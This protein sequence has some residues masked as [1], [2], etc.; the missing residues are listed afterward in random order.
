MKNYRKCL[1]PL[2]NLPFFLTAARNKS[3]STA[4]KELF[5][6][7]AAV[8]KRIQRLE[9]WLG[10]DLF[11]RNGRNLKIS[12]AGKEFASDVEMALDFL[13][14][15]VRKIKSPEEPVVRIATGTTISAYW[16]YERL[17]TFS[18]SE[19][20]CNIYVSTSDSTAEVMSESNDLFVLFCD[21]Y[22]QGLKCMK[23]FDCE[24]APAAAPDVAD[25]IVHSGIF[26]DNKSNSDTPPLLEY[27]NMNPDWVNWEIWLREMGKPEIKHWP[28]LQCDSFIESIAKARAGLGICLMH[29]PMM[30]KEI[31]DGALVKIDTQSYIT[32]KSYYLCHHE[33]T[34][35][36]QNA[37]NLLEF[38]LGLDM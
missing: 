9:S 37:K 12:N 22:V 17:Q 8:S 4:A 24:L 21:G 1:P 26:S 15:A 36:S 18:R 23:I 31:D 34:I 3:L 32:K 19:N 33:G 14:R 7:Q 11:K 2:D 30:Q 6:T 35:L 20:A 25:D 10:V 13:D 38:L 5:V 27:S 16:L 29:Q 28:T